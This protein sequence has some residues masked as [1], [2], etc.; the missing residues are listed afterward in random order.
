MVSDSLARLYTAA[1]L[2]HSLPNWFREL[3]KKLRGFNA[4]PHLKTNDNAL[5]NSGRHLMLT[6]GCGT[7]AK[8]ALPMKITLFV[9]DPTDDFQ[10]IHAYQRHLNRLSKYCKLEPEPSKPTS[11]Y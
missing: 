11:Y 3:K 1:L 2:R 6:H 4:F 9:R 10:N 8:R 7:R 5:R